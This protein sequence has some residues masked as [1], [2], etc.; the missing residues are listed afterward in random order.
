MYDMGY[1]ISTFVGYVNT[2]CDSANTK[3]YT[4]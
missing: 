3:S 1:N 4:V 2:V